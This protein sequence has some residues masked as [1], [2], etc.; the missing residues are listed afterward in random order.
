MKRCFLIPK[1]NFELSWLR[2]HVRPRDVVVPL[3]MSAFAFLREFSPHVSTVEEWVSY[4][5]I[6][7]LAFQATEINQAFSAESCQKQTFEGYDWPRICRN[8]QDFFF[9]DILLAEALAFSLKENGG[10]RIVWVGN[11]TH[12]AHLSTLTS[13]VVA[14]TFSFYLGKRFE[15]LKAPHQ[16]QAGVIARYGLKIQNVFKL[17]KKRIVFSREVRIPKCE[18]IAISSPPEEWMRFS[19]ALRELHGKYGE[20]FQ[21]WSVGRPS[22]ELREWA[23]A[24]GVRVVW[25]PYPDRT[26]KEVMSFFK[27]H[28][29]HWQKKGRRKFAEK[30]GCSVLASDQLDYHF[31][32]FFMKVW[33]RMVEYAR[34]LESYLKMAEPGWLIGSTDPT[35]S[36]LF[37]YHVAKKLGI[38][39]I[40]MPHGYVQVGGVDIE[41]SFLA[42]R[43]RFER[44]H[45]I[46][47]FADD[48]EVLYCNNAGNELSYQPE[49]VDISN[50][51]N[52][53]I[54]AILTCDPDIEGTFM[55]TAN[56]QAFLHTFEE[57]EDLPEEFSDLE[58]VIKS[59]PRSD[60]SSFFHHLHFPAN[61]RVV[62]P[63]ASLFD[64]TE[65]A[66][67]IIMVNYF[68]SAVVHAIKAEKPI[69][70]L[71]S[72]GSFW[73]H[74][75][76][77][78][79][80]AGEVVEDVSDL[81]DLLR[82]LKNSPLFY[83]TLQRKCQRFKSEYL[84]STGETLGKRIY[85]SQDTPRSLVNEPPFN[86]RPCA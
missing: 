82:R 70:F 43:N 2:K 28:W 81:W 75:E 39:T 10:E 3:T 60:L 62:D 26:G 19:D 8:M 83:Q 76:W 6:K 34:L 31:E 41:T 52:K 58:F 51:D 77:L 16:T 12:E 57:L 48:K 72:A 38:R 22:K 59:H 67:V 15:V 69:L 64:L 71:N 20:K 65:K 32:F 46:R 33:P 49:N 13:N 37:P 78:A 4:K 55:S 30:V 44:S 50:A 86:P 25:V 14:S 54:V 80:P 24:E 23:K 63:K 9:R 35:T 53:N 73:P 36:K 47:S 45:F 61:M 66:W 7:G 79:F 68:G 1:I 11:P 84:A 18:V 5:D 74:T 27:D 85:A 40:A 21:F 29:D 17:F 56:R 42:C